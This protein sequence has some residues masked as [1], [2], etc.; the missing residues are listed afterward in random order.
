[1]VVHQAAFFQT[2]LDSVK[3]NLVTWDESDSLKS[4]I[5]LVIRLDNCCHNRHSSELSESASSLLTFQCSQPSESSEYHS[6]PG[7]SS[8]CHQNHLWNGA[9]TVGK[10]SAEDIWMALPAPQLFRSL[11]PQPLRSPKKSHLFAALHSPPRWNMLQAI[12]RPSKEMA[13]FLLTRPTFNPT[14]R[15]G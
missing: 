5:S 1:M 7:Q 6:P 4:L 14:D 2:L 3:E 11:V 12:S 9:H 15:F 10:N 8:K 13:S